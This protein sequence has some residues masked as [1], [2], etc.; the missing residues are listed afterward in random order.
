MIPKILIKINKTPPEPNAT[1]PTFLILEAGA[2]L[3]II[4]ETE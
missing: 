2:T 4:E 1:I 3:L